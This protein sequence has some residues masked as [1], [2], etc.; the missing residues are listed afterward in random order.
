[1][2]LGLVF[3]FGRYVHFGFALGG[4]RCQ[5]GGKNRAVIGWTVLVFLRVGMSPLAGRKTTV[6][7]LV[8]EVVVFTRPG[9]AA[10]AGCSGGGEPQQTGGGGEAW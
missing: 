5:K 8:G 9:P 2:A 1:M 4:T 7:S 6:V 3:V 10:G